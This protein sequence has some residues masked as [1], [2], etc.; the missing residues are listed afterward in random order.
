MARDDVTRRTVKY[1]RKGRVVVRRPSLQVVP[2]DSAVHHLQ[3]LTMASQQEGGQRPSSTGSARATGDVQEMSRTP[4]SSVQGS[5][6]QHSAAPSVGPREMS[7]SPRSSAR[8]SASAAES[9]NLRLDVI[10]DLST[11]MTGMDG[12]DRRVFNR[13]LMNAASAQD[14]ERLRAM[15]AQLEAVDVRTRVEMLSIMV[16]LPSRQQQQQQHMHMEI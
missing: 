12:E 16:S 3:L 14:V 5:G 1:A 6:G 2:E 15:R 11:L 4:R 8:G 13:W 10:S 9:M 7:R